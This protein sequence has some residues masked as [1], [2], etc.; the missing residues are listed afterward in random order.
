MTGSW[1]SVTTLFLK[2]LM[3]GVEGRVSVRERGREGGKDGPF[4]QHTHHWRTFTM[5]TGVSRG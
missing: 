1:D 3:G 5:D 4:N 2:S